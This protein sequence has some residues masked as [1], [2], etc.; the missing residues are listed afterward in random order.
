MFDAKLLTKAEMIL[1]ACREQGMKIAVA[2]SCTGGLIASLFTAISGS[3]DVFDRGFVTY[4]N[5][6]KIEMLGVPDRSLQIHGAVSET[7]AAAMA[8]G[9]LARSDAVLSVSVTGI[10]GPDG[11]SEEKPVG[12]VHFG[13]AKE[14]A[15]TIH[16]REI[17]NGDRHEIRMDAVR[18]ALRLLESRL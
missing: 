5:R 16:D 3:S 11:G 14:G 7:T 18:H 9:A 10:A 17:F 6:A 8:E 4:S 1:Q 13:C 12:L 15:P 2:E